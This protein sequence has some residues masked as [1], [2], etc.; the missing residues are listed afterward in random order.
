MT[1]RSALQGVNPVIA[2][3]MRPP[4]RGG[5]AERTGPR[6]G[7]R[8][9]ASIILSCLAVSAPRINTVLPSLRLAGEAGTLDKKIDNF[10]P[11]RLGRG[12][13]FQKGQQAGWRLPWAPARGGFDVKDG[14]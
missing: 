1:G 13:V 3:P 14:E 5:P 8:P 7:D 10:L 11:R 4:F 9:R 12:I 2:P 6:L